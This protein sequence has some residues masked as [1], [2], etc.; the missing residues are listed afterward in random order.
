MNPKVTVIIPT[1]NRADKVLGAIESALTQTYRAHE[2]IVVDDG[3]TDTT[4]EVVKRYTEDAVSPGPPVHY[5]CQ[6]KQGVSGARNCGIDRASG[7]WIA[8]LDSDDRWLPRKLERQMQ[9][10]EKYGGNYGACFTD[11]RHVN[12]P[13]WQ[14]TVFE[15]SEGPFERPTGCL[16]NAPYLIAGANHGI[17][18]QTLII[19]R[20]VVDRAG[21][22]DPHLRIFEDNDFAF[23][24]GLHTKYC[25]VNE[26]LVEIDRAPGRPEGLIELYAREGF[27]LEQQQYEHEKWLAEG[28][29]LDIRV[30]RRIFDQLQNNRAAWASW[31]VRNGEYV[32]GRDAMAMVLRHGFTVRS[33]IKWALIWLAPDFTRGVVQKRYQRSLRAMLPGF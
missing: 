14:R 22:F 23:Q 29:I 9:A 2:I 26:T 27:R 16:S 3:S 18:V 30:R 15:E 28:E 6:E 31:Y 24:V 7:A 25:Y 12:N 10:L 33:L 21:L 20:D 1:Y 17:R 11:A 4:K 8:F 19:H 13:A 5:V 32:K